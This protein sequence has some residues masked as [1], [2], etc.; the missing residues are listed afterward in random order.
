ML[1]DASTRWVLSHPNRNMT[2]RLTTANSCRSLHVS[3]LHTHDRCSTRQQPGHKFCC[4][5]CVLVDSVHLQ[6]KY[7]YA[8]R[9]PRSFQCQE[10]QLISWDRDCR[11]EVGRSKASTHSST[12]YCLR[13]AALPREHVNKGPVSQVGQL[14]CDAQ[15]KTAAKAVPHTSRCRHWVCWLRCQTLLI[16]VLCLC[17]LW[18]GHLL[19][20]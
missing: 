18:C 6:Q 4:T 2:P 20:R 7:L 8:I 13:L 16:Q 9:S 19:T 11:S 17:H 12:S 14:C 5:V 1:S 3:C 15:T 10:P